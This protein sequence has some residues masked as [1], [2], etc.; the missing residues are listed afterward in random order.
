[1]P[2]KGIRRPAAKAVA[3]AGVRRPA[4]GP[5][6]RPAGAGDPP[7]LGDK[8]I[9]GNFKE[10]GEVDVGDLP[11]QE[12]KTGGRV[13]FTEAIYWEEKAK[14]AGVIKGLRL[15]EGQVHL[16]LKCAGSRW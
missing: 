7:P 15:E 13:V 10:G 5:L 6:R 11:I 8:D 4:R 9:S 3:R 1:M 16:S 14:V 12:W 2:P